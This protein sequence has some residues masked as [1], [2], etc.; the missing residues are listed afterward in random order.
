MSHG[1]VPLSQTARMPG[2]LRALP[3]RGSQLL[4]SATSL[5]AVFLLGL[6]ALPT[7]EAFGHAS[8]L[9]SACSVL[10][11]TL[12]VIK[13]RVACLA[14]IGALTSF[15]INPRIASLSQIDVY[16]ADVFY[17][18]LIA[19]VLSQQALRRPSS[20]EQRVRGLEY[21]PIVFFLAF[22][23]FTVGQ[24]ALTDPSFFAISAI[25][26][27]RLVQ[28]ASLIPLVVQIVRQHDDVVFL[29][30][31]I[32]LGGLGASAIGT[33]QL[34]TSGSLIFGRFGGP[35][36]VNTLGLVS[37]L[38][39]V[40][41]VFPGITR[42]LAPRFAMC[43]AGIL[44][45]IA[46]KSVG[47]M[48]AVVV[49]VGIGAILTH[50]RRGAFER[51]IKAIILVTIGTL[52]VLGFAR[53]F[54]PDLVPGS[55]Q[56]GYSSATHRLV[57]GASGLQLFIEHPLIGVGWQRSA[58]PDVIGSV[59]VVDAVKARFSE[60]VNPIFFPNVTPTSVHNTYVQL[61][62][63]LGILGFSL[64]AFL[65][66]RLGG[67]IHR[68]LKQLRHTRGMPLAHQLAISLIAILTWWNDNPLYG[69][70]T[71][72]ILASLFLGSLFAL[73]RLHAGSGTSAS[74]TTVHPLPGR[75]L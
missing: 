39:I 48:S 2:H 65:V 19:F 14:L 63:E 21:W 20:P 10:A 52:L 59:D 55:P 46:S 5:A 47:G 71:E 16:V 28:T 33:F 6:M 57:L 8:L 31:S 45:L 42:S 9:V 54:R 23:G 18:L 30:G 12:I 36:S 1:I 56:F 35:L 67:G 37:A 43:L 49:A 29:L 62:A 61:L 66:L 34:L 64:F 27:L 44:G 72:S 13:G 58:S 32:A 73:P 7:T 25:S 41:A 68:L 69:G 22:V 17:V 15:G 51:A 70:Q 11:A 26:W 60:G 50:P 75:P 4:L 74:H 3:V 53:S 24:V 38:L 40:A